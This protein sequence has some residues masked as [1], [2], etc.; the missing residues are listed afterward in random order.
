[1][2]PVPTGVIVMYLTGIAS[3]GFFALIVYSEDFISRVKYASFTV[4]MASQYLMALLNYSNAM[5]EFNQNV[6]VGIAG[7]AAVGLSLKFYEEFYCP[8]REQWGS[9][10]S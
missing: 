1:M 3:V 4:L 5:V 9:S 8:L 2:L 6:Y 7:V 10:G